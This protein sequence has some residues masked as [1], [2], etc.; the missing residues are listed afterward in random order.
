MRSRIF[1]AAVFALV[2]GC[3][4]TETVTFRNPELGGKQFHKV[5]VYGNIRD[6]MYRKEMEDGLVRSLSLKG[7]QAV[8]SLAIVSPDASQEECLIAY[9][10]NG[11]DC[12]LA[13]V[14]DGASVSEHVISG[15][16]A[17]TSSSA[18]CFGGNCY[19]QTTTR[20]NPG[21]TAYK[22]HMNF[23][24]RVLDLES[25]KVAWQSQAH[26]NGNGYANFHTV[27]ASFQEKTAE[28]LAQ[29]GLFAPRMAQQQ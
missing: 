9:R 27:I 16:T 21:V 19:G 24:A 23:A 2:L 3:A 10:N 7:I 25:M 18:N 14:V 1:T 11:A 4:S 12:A 26:G 15:P 22:P 20:V 8:S 29:A 5:V 6:L 17:T 13:V 28:D